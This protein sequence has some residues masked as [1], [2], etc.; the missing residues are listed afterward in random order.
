MKRSAFFALVT[1]LFTMAFSVISYAAGSP[2]TNG[3]FQTGNFSGWTYHDSTHCDFGYCGNGTASVQHCTPAAPGDT[4]GYCAVFSGARV[5]GGQTPPGSTNAHKFTIGACM[6]H[7]GAGTS[8]IQFGAI[9]YSVS[10][11][12]SWNCQTATYI[13][14]S[15]GTVYVPFIY[16]NNVGGTAQFDQ[17]SF[18]VITP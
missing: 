13:N 15:G 9:R 14:S 17:F 7:S 5:W 11:G 16:F 1:T 4:D 3:S 2:I 18:T 6:N 12:S 10:G 8:T